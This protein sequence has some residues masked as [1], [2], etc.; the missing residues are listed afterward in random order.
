MNATQSSTTNIVRRAKACNTCRRKK[1]KCDGKR[2]I[3]SPCHAFNL[4]CGYQDVMDRRKRE[5]RTYV[6]QLEKRIEKMQEQLESLTRSGSEIQRGVENTRRSTSPGTSVESNT[7]YGEPEDPTDGDNIPNMPQVTSDKGPRLPAENDQSIV[8][9]AQ[10]GKM[11]YFGASSAFSALTNAE[12]NR[13]EAQPDTGVWRRAPQRSASPWQL[14]SWIPHILQDGLERRIVEPLPCKDT[15]VQLAREYFAT[16]N[17][18]IPLFEEASFMR[19]VDRQYSWNPDNSASWW[20]SLNIALAISYRERAHASSDPSDDWKKSLGHVKNALNA[21]VDVFLRNTDIAAVQG[22]LGLALYF[23]GTPNPQ[24]LLMFAAAAMRLAQ[25]I[26]LHRGNGSGASPEAEHRRRVYWIAFIL[27]SDISIRVGRPPVQDFED[28]DTHLPTENPPDGKGVLMIDGTRMNYFRLLAQ[29]AQIQRLVYRKLYTVTVRQESSD[30]VIERIKSCEDALLSWKKTLHSRLQPQRRFS[31]E[32]TYFLQHVLRLHFAYN[33]CYSNLYQVCVFQANAIERSRQGTDEG[34]AP[35]VSRSLDA[36]RS[37]LALLSHVPSLGS[38][39]KWNIIYFPAA[40][41]VPLALRILAQPAHSDAG[42]DLLMVQN[43]I[44][45][46]ARTSSEEP[47]TYVDFVLGMCSDLER[48]ARR[49]FMTAKP[50]RNHHPAIMQNNENDGPSLSS[51][52]INQNTAPNFSDTLSTPF[53]SASAAD[54]ASAQFTNVMQQGPYP[55]IGFLG[56]STVDQA[57]NWQ[58]SL[59]PFWN[60]QDLVSG[61]PSFPVVPGVDIPEANMPDT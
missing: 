48:S 49:A 50:A 21:V 39:Y 33:C 42:D 45:F 35:I 41:C 55:D 10:D 60:W 7:N 58:W 13:L 19:S 46:L 3:C 27:D 17:Q 25:S 30:D 56:P 43:V 26:G 9:D 37:A 53:A 40:A 11:R 29:L 51:H 6:E 38:T 2:P 8:I 61:A 57:A 34:I 28:Y 14:S 20:I 36:A 4:S 32:P 18:A 59:P 31:C 47:N 12:L 54:M 16:F 52:E 1:V 44:G 15:T 5:S 23:Q 24:A 22:F